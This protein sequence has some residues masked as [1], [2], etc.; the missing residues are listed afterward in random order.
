LGRSL[1]ANAS[2]EL[3]GR[4]EY[5]E[6]RAAYEKALSLQPAPIEAQVYMANLFTDT[7][8]VE[9]AVPLL[10]DALKTN[11]NHAEVHWELGYAY[12][13]AGMLKESVA[14]CTSARRLDPGVKLGSSALNAYLYLG[15][16]DAFLQS[17][18][19]D[20]DSALILFYRAFGEYHKKN[21]PQAA[22][23]FDD[24][25]DLRSTL[26]HARIGKALSDGIRQQGQKGIE[27]LREIEG[28]ISARGVGD[29]EA[30]YKISQAYAMLGD[31]PAALRALRSSIEGGFFAYPYLLTDPLLESLRPDVEF[32][33]LLTAARERHE[34]FKHRFF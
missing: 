7:G 28:R 30:M 10:R 6:A 22:K 29:P 11:P 24:A 4:E 25:F 14:E 3:G 9:R 2:F 32:Q 18:P 5:R 13:F 20:S 8:Q 19:K 26:L 31:R 1:T 16:Y 23:G 21:L 15:Q 27:I 34:A 12:R 33:R 17:L